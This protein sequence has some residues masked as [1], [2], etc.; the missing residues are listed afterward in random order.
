MLVSPTRSRSGHD[1]I[2]LDEAAAGQR[3]VEHAPHVVLL[4][5]TDPIPVLVELVGRVHAA[6]ERAHR[7]AGNRF[8]AESLHEKFFDDADVRVT[9]R[10]AGAEY[11]RDAAGR[12]S[13]R[14]HGSEEFVAH[15][16]RSLTQR[17]SR[18]PRMETAASLP[19][20]PHK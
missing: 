6:D 11:E 10:A 1:A 9:A 15:V 12:N 14:D 18:E 2:A 19:G 7:T 4:H 20:V 5:R 17:P 13:G 8:D 16:L 3:P